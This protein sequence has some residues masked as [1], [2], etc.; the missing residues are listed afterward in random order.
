VN[1][2]WLSV[3]RDRFLLF[4]L[5]TPAVLLAAGNDGF[6]FDAPGFVDPF[7]YL[8]HFWHYLEHLPR[9]DN[10]YK[11]SRLPWV[12]PGFAA[13]ALGGEIVGA[14]LLNYLMMAAGSIALYLLIRD[15]LNDRT[16]ASVVAVA[17]ACC[18]QGHGV[19]GWNYHMGAAGAY[20][21]AACWLVLR[22][23]K[24][25]SPQ[26]AALL[27]GVLLACAVHTHVFVVAFFPLVAFLYWSASPPAQVSFAARSGRHLLLLVL[28]ALS[29][30]MVLMVVNG[31]TG[32]EWLFFE[33]QIDFTL[34]EWRSDTYPLWKD[35]PFEWMPAAMHLVLPV[36]FMMAG[37]SQ[38]SRA[39]GQPSSRLRISL[40]VQ[41]WA[42]F[43]ILCFFQFARRVPMLDHDYFAF[44]A[45]FYAFPCVA[46]ALASDDA[47]EGRRRLATVAVAA[48]VM[49]GSLMVL[50]PGAL[51]HFVADTS[52][53]IGLAGLP[54]VA[55]PLAVGFVGVVAMMLLSGPVRLIA[56]A[57]WF[58]VV[59]TWIAPSPADYGIRTPGSQ[60]QMVALFREA[61]RFA[62]ELDP[63]LGGIKYWFP[64]EE[65]ATPT[66]TLALNWVFDS[67]L[68][69]RGWSASLFGQQSPGP[70]IDTLTAE[71][72]SST[73]C[74]G[75]LSSVGRHDE[76]RQALSAHFDRLG[77]PLSEVA[78]RRFERPALAFALTVFK[79]RSATET[80]PPCWPL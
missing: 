32:G 31:V 11:I 53:A 6:G 71:H 51:A 25:P 5:L 49:V 44:V 55:L 43:A 54:P 15:A 64:K 21:L 20:Y 61:D 41:A 7:I 38:L 16:T 37:L 57:L 39:T 4:P 80:L 36:L 73:T 56:F 34:R 28:G 29:I 46:A 77:Q 9:F 76:L 23:A 65:V 67:F 24:G 75:L 78:S 60:Q 35:D 58:A 47:F 10:D 12:L 27:A 8:G 72:L 22:A 62:T 1:S 3:V 74:L 2:R 30:T 26:R 59:N 42:A 79:R 45:Y 68:S 17:W 69:T 40:V 33:N 19:G 50:L 63:T 13:H 14:Y 48:L 66:G 70:A 18:T 52:A